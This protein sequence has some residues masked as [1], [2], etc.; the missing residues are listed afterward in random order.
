MTNTLAYHDKELITTEKSLTAQA[1]W[2]SYV[3]LSIRSCATVSAYSVH[4]YKV[5]STRT[6]TKIIIIL[7][8]NQ[9]KNF[10]HWY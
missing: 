4:T 1:A 2:C 8:V 7:L 6:S 9:K 5:E 3:P 10:L